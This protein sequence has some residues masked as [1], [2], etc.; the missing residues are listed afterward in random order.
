MAAGN[1]SAAATNIF[2][3]SSMRVCQPAPLALKKLMTSGDRRRLVATLT[4][5]FYP[6][7]ADVSVI[8]DDLVQQ[9]LSHDKTGQQLCGWKN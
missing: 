5:S 1:Y 9:I 8:S 4:D 2:N 6:A 7:K 3:T